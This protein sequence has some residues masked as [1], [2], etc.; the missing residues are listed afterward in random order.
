MS[1][2][3]RMKSAAR[4]AVLHLAV[5]SVV[6]ALVALIVLKLWY[7]AP[8]DQLSSG[9]SLFFLLILVDIACGPLLTLLV[10]NPE[11]SRFKWRFNLAV[12]VVLQLCAL[13]YGLHAT[14][15]ARPVFLAFEGN[16]FRVVQAN[17]V[18]PKRLNDARPEFATLSLTGPRLLGTR[19]AQS[20][21]ADFLASLQLSLNGL[22]PAFRPDRWVPYL[23]QQ[24]QVL[25]EL[26]PL[27]ELRARNPD[28]SNEIDRMVHAGGMEESQL[29]YLPLV[30]DEKNDWVVV[31]A[32]QD[33][34]PRNYLHMEGW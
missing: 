8:Y 24:G 22:P 23:E 11:K 5:S 21:D 18:D 7:P 17:D 16:R 28:K 20:T 13:S 6:A 14:A 34:L 25:K 27:S 33:A 31:V 2:L 29:G 12:I 1:F 19:L 26:K 15:T 30:N 4:K 32:R 10:F 3:V 9:R